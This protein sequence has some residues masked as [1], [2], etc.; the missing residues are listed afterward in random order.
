VRDD[1]V[2]CSGASRSEEQNGVSDLALLR[3]IAGC[4]F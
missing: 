1:E 4:F 3:I 2:S